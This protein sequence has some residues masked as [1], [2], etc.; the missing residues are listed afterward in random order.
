MPLAQRWAVSIPPAVTL[1]GIVAFGAVLG[2][3][4]VLLAMP[5]IVVTMTLVNK[6]YV[7]PLK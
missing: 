5:L 1:L 3:M 6:L 7:E 4:G 2:P